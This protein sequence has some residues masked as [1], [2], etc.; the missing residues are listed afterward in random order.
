MKLTPLSRI[1]S[2][3]AMRDE[4]W[5]L[6]SESPAVPGDDARFWGCRLPG[7][8]WTDE[9][10]PFAIAFGGERCETRFVSSW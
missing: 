1:L 7:P 4:P 3:S 10:E 5:P 9:R 8:F 2:L 6:L